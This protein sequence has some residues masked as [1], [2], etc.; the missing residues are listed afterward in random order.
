[1]GSAMHQNP[2]NTDETFWRKAGK[3][4]WSYVANLEEYVGSNVSVITDYKHEQ[5]IHSDSWFLWAHL[6]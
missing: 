4:Y 3:E 6:E 5:N 1:M 2:S